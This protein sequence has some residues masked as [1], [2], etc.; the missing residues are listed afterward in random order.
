[1]IKC[2]NEAEMEAF[3]SWLMPYCVANETPYPH[4]PNL[5]SAQE[6]VSRI[7]DCYLGLKNSALTEALLAS[8]AGAVFT[9]NCENW[10]PRFNPIGAIG[11]ESRYMLNNKL[12]DNATLVGFI[13]AEKVEDCSEAFL[14]RFFQH[15]YLP[16]GLSVNEGNI[17]R[18]DQEVE[19][20]KFYHG[21]WQQKL[22]GII[23]MA[24]A[25]LHLKSKPLVE[26]SKKGQKVKLVNLPDK[27]ECRQTIDEVQEKGYYDYIL[28][29]HDS[30]RAS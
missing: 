3:Q 1:M 4:I 20:I 26:I 25:S 21:E 13:L 7:G 29:R 9:M 22:F 8:K 24:E 27:L 12:K 14:S 11:N 19:E 2:E 10:H 30:L 23:S 17:Q 16:S 6:T 28:K 18:F 15:S 5:K